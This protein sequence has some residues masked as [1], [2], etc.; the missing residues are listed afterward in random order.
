MSS[1]KD[2]SDKAL[3]K[4]AEEV[5][6]VVVA[7]GRQIEK[8]QERKRLAVKELTALKHEQHRRAWGMASKEGT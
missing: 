4:Q 6:R 7:A 8:Y 1:Y 5:E 2:W 3:A